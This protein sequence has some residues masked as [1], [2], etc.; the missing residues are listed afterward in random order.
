MQ[1]TASSCAKQICLIQEVRRRNSKE[2]DI[3][4]KYDIL[5]RFQ[6]SGYDAVRKEEMQKVEAM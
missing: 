5:C 4:L 1:Q 6:I 2:T 3:F